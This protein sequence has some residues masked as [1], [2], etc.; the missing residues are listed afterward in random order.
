MNK[1]ATKIT[2]LLL[3]MLTAFS[4]VACGGDKGKDKDSNSASDST[5]DK[6]YKNDPENRALVLAS[7]ALDGNFNPFFATS[8][9]DT[10]IASMTQIG[11]L[12]TDENGNI[13]CGIDEPTVALDYKITEEGEGEEKKTTYELL[14]K[15]GIKFS[16]GVELTIKDVL[17]NLYVYLDPAYTGSATIY[18]TDIVGLKDYRTQTPNS[19]LTDGEMNANFLGAAMQRRQN[20]IDYLDSGKADEDD[21]Y[22][23]EDE[24]QIEEDIEL[25]KEMFRE[26]VETDWTNNQG[27]LESY[28]DEYTFTEDWQIYYF[29]EGYVTVWAQQGKPMKDIDGK[30]I[31]NIT[32]AGVKYKTLAGKEETYNGEYLTPEITEDIEDAMN[33]TSKTDVYVNKGVSLEEAKE[34]VAKD[35]AIDTIYGKIDTDAGLIQIVERWATGANILDHFVAD[36]RSAYFDKNTAEDGGLKVKNI[37]GITTY[38]T[39]SFSGKIT[40]DATFTEDHDVLKIQ[41]NDVDPKAIYNFAFG[42]APM[43]YY[44]GEFEGVDYVAKADGKNNFGV[45]FA[46]NKFF[47]TVLQNDKVNALPVGAGAYQVSNQKGETKNVKGDDFYSNNWVYFARNDNFK[48]L[49]GSFQNAKIKFIRY[50]VVNSDKLIQALEAKNIDIGEPSATATNIAAIGKISHLSQKTVNTNGYGYVGINPKYVP[51]IEIRRIIMGVLEP[52]HCIDY[53]TSNYASILY[54]SMSKES[55]IWKE[56]GITMPNKPYYDIITD[57]D[58]VKAAISKLPDW[59]L[60]SNGVFANSKTGATLKLTFTIAGATTDHPAFHM[61][62]QAAEFLNDCGFDITVATDIQALKKLASGQLEVWA[63]AWSSTADPDMYQVYHKDSKATS[64]N[65]WGYPTILNDQSGQFSYEQTIIDELSALI[66]E[67]RETTN[68]LKRAKTYVKALDKVMDLA[69]ELPTYQRKDCVA[70]NF[71]LIDAASLNQNATAFRGVID[72]IWE[73]DYN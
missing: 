34:M 22:L 59:S 12:T 60:N 5:V 10:E 65:N 11:M 35:F 69:V 32:P 1:T 14:L 61:F 73:L 53:Y 41:I 33:D 13:T 23:P 31:T 17:F 6:V 57:K 19:T 66:E 62:T 21:T 16:D 64:V 42:V 29:A 8:G 39:K 26:E 55:W 50:R 47:D 15:N 52:R 67:G 51:D 63:A 68:N 58:A 7:E 54:R 70:Y 18:S 24:P 44:S 43:H 27:T 4:L 25:L 2:C 40:K 3:S 9:P 38:T 45:A 49:G 71:E 48:S 30:Y 72:K 36:E 20:I 37:S 46:N 56:E 28:K